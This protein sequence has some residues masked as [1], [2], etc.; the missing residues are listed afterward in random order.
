MASTVVTQGFITIFDE[1]RGAWRAAPGPQPLLLEDDSLAQSAEA[2][3]IVV[4]FGW[5]A[6]LVRTGEAVLLLGD[7]GY[8]EESAPLVRS[9][10]EH[11][12]GLSWLV[13]QRGPAFQ[14]LL[15]MRAESLRRF[16]AAQE[17]GW[18]LEG[19][20]AQELLQ[21]AIDVETD[22]ETRFLDRFAAVRTQAAH[23][24]LGSFYQG[25][26]IESS[27]SHASLDS[28]QPYYEQTSELSVSLRATPE[29]RFIER[30]AIVV[31]SVHAALVA[32]NQIVQSA[33]LADQLNS[34]LLRL[35]EL[36]AMLAEEHRTGEQQ[37]D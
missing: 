12:I 22:D 31:S 16:Q 24:G 28:A 4:A 37:A 15:R 19:P 30:E 1:M 6:R 20:E 32:Y 10:I 18:T 11:C 34:W 5:M 7:N 21:R 17:S 2:G 27:S 8:R 23:Y 36:G 9:M 33:S 26:L 35:Q 3:A 14:V 13:D 25:W 29:A